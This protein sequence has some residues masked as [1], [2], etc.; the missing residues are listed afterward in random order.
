LLSSLS[1]ASRSRTGPGSGGRSAGPLPPQLR[2]PGKSGR[3]GC[4]RSAGTSSSACPRITT[5]PRQTPPRHL[6]R[7]RA[8]VSR[9]PR[10][11]PCQPGTSL[12]SWPTTVVAA[13]GG[14][15]DPARLGRGSKMPKV[16]DAVIRLAPE[17]IPPGLSR[18]APQAR[19]CNGHQRSPTDN[20]TQA[21]TCRN[22]QNPSSPLKVPSLQTAA[23]NSGGQGPPAYLHVRAVWCCTVCH[24][25]VMNP[26]QVLAVTRSIVRSYP[27][28]AGVALRA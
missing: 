20:Q 18:S 6:L 2:S 21:L 8:P 1:C 23:L 7:T 16:G 17:L 27:D 12:S 26:D 5:G 28:E 24:P 11:F 4:R 19:V 9:R 25:E 13:A 10:R 14:P 3:G 22:A 15:L